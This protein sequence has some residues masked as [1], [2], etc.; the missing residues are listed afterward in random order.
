VQ[1]PEQQSSP[2]LQTSSCARQPLSRAQVPAPAPPAS[3]QLP[4][5][6]LPFSPSGLQGSPW[7]RHDPS[8]AQCP[9]AAPSG[10]SQ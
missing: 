4:E 2:L 9:T 3:T 7:V 1:L 5:Q 10:R 8:A 6:Q